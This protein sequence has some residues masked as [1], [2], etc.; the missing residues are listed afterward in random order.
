MAYDQAANRIKSGSEGE[1]DRAAVA[2]AKQLAMAREHPGAA[3]AEENEHEAG[4]VKLLEWVKRILALAE[5]G[6]K[7]IGRYR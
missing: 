4:K 3:P 6:K 2:F 5:K 7:R 1:T